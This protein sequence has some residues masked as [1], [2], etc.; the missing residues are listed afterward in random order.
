MSW[1]P[2]VEVTETSDEFTITAEL[3]GMKRKDVH[4]DFDYE[5]LTLRREKED[6]RE[7][8]DPARRYYVCERNDGAFQRSFSL[9]LSDM[10]KASADFSDGLLTVHVPK[11]AHARTHSRKIEIVDKK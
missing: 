9:P 7:E 10:D 1:Y 6:K 4:L 3:P 5:T 2:P 11:L 8:K